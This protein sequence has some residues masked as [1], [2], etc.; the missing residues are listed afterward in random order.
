MKYT[1]KYHF[2]GFIDKKNTYALDVL[3][4]AVDV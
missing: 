3:D 1:F 2:P 4:L